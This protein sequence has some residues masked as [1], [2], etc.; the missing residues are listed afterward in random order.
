VV[1]LGHVPAVDQP[2]ADPVSACYWYRLAAHGNDLDAQ[3]QL[4][5]HYLL[6]SGVERNEI[7][8]REWLSRSADRGHVTATTRL[9]SLNL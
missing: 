3:Y 9:A 2:A 7:L 8:A 5:E 1:F 4:G 6:G